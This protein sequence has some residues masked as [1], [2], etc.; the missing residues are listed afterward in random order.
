MA[1]HPRP[2]GI[3]QVFIAPFPGLVGQGRTPLERKRR[4]IWANR[5]RNRWVAGLARGLAAAPRKTL[6]GLGLSPRT[7][8]LP[9]RTR[10]RVVVLAETAEHARNL[11]DHLPLWDALDAAPV[12]SPEAGWAAAPDEAE[13]PPPGR[14]ATLVYAARYGIGCDVLV[15]ATAGT[16]PLDWASIRAVGFRVGTRPALVVDVADQAGERE[17]T[18]AEVRRREYFQH[19]LQLLRPRA[20]QGTT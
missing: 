6:R 3:T 16:G 18:D 4:A 20:D 15:R 9:V 7:V 14:I 2:T 1:P 8:H 13:P 10:Q 17:S 12:T 11:E 5:E 19:G